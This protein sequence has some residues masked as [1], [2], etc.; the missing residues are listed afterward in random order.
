METLII[1]PKNK[2]QMEAIKAVLNALNISFKKEEESPY[3]PR[4]VTKINT[5]RKN[6]EKGE[7]VTIDPKKS[8]WENIL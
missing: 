3:D 2:K 7:Y 1:Q 6:I 5:A 8:L 4:F